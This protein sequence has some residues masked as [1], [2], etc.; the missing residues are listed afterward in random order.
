MLY[1]S[2]FP[3][4]VRTTEFW[5][6]AYQSGK[7]V[8]A[9]RVD[10]IARRLRLHVVQDPDKDLCPGM[11]GIPEPSEKLPEV[12]PALID[13]VLVPGLAFS[14]QGYRL[15]RGAGH[16][17]QLLPE[18][19]P[20]AICWAMCL[21]CQLV[22]GLPIEPHDLPLNG[23]CTPNRIIKGKRGVPDSQSP[24]PR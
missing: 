14:E 10:R 5:G 23:V 15:G 6:R 11:L 19:R 7:L 2:T 1:V 3:E 20:D 4:E 16:Y 17:D 13:W 8:I 12:S 18:L 9:P 24:P 21:S 22:D